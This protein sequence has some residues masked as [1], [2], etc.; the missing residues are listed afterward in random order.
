MCVVCES[1]WKAYTGNYDELCDDHYLE[2]EEQS[3]EE[4]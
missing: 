4:E 3:D 2:A 1:G